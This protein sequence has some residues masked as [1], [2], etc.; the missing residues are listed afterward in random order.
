MTDVARTSAPSSRKPKFT[1]FSQQQIWGK[2][3]ALTPALT[4]KMMISFGVGCFAVGGSIWNTTKDLRTLEKRY[5]NIVTCADGFFPTTEEKTMKRSYNGAGTTCTVTL[6]A[7]SNMNKPVY[8]Y[9]ELSNFFQNHRAFVRD[10][11]YFQ[12]MGKPAQGLCTTHEKTSTGDTID[13]CG[14]QAWSFFNDSYAVAV[15]GAAVTIDSTNIAWK[16]DLKYKLGDYAPMNMNTDQA[17]RGGAQITGNVDS[18]ED[19]ATWMRTAAM[20]KFRKLVG[21]IRT[22]IVAGDEITFTIQN[23]YNTYMFKGEKAVILATNSWIGG[24][25]L[26]F[27]A[28]YFLVGTLCSG[29]GAFG[30]FLQCFGEKFKS[31]STNEWSSRL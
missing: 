20:S 1:A 9:Y 26:V 6:T 28:L 29:L 24:R 12:L 2:R 13:P 18:D 10:L 25:N 23:R 17:T 30:V 27:P 14:V 4:A 21:V 8:V 3:P 31:Q 16:S 19:F 22:D 5:D 7:T 15:N 11:D